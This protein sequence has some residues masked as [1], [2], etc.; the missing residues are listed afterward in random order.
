MNVTT[1]NSTELRLLAENTVPGTVLGVMSVIWTCWLFFSWLM[2]WP[3]NI[4]GNLYRPPIYYLG[5]L[6]SDGF[7]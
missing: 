5:T 4:T 1:T 3:N 7:F 2:P 6:Q